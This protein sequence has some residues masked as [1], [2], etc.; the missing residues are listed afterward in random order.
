MTQSI[1]GFFVLQSLLRNAPA[2]GPA[3]PPWRKPSTDASATSH[4]WVLPASLRLSSPCS[5]VPPTPQ[6]SEG[7][8]TQCRRSISLKIPLHWVQGEE[9]W[10]IRFPSHESQVEGQ[11]L[12]CSWGCIKSFYGEGQ[13][14]VG[15][16]RGF[17]SVCA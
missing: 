17:S 10:E 9:P 2:V 6:C 16:Q 4:P 13:K 15:H 1:S 3:A 14:Q 5:A 11:S 7:L 8:S 12:S